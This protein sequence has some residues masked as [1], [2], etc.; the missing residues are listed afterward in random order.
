MS[1]SDD[2]EAEKILR[3]KVREHL[4]MLLGAHKNDAEDALSGESEDGKWYESPSEEVEKRLKT[5]LDAH[6]EEAVDVT[7]NMKRYVGYL[8]RKDFQKRLPNL[9][10]RMPATE[11]LLIEVSFWWSM[12]NALLTLFVEGSPKD[13]PPLHS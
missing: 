10:E 3:K 5:L 9:A 8:A 2:Q 1:D 7:L 11:S 13:K 6:V 12:H 4:R